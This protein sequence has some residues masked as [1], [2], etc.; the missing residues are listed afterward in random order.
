MLCSLGEFRHLMAGIFLDILH[1]CGADM[2][3][4]GYIVLALI[5][6]YQ[7]LKQKDM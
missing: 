6:K 5:S 2:I 7:K 1:F 4:M 3:H